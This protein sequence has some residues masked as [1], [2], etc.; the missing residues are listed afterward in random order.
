MSE[1]PDEV[2]MAV[3]ALE[4]Q[5]G[6][7]NHSFELRSAIYDLLATS[8]TL[9]EEQAA[10]I[11]GL[12]DVLEEKRENINSLRARLSE[13]VKVIEMF[14]HSVCHETGFANAVRHDSGH[15]YPWPALDQT[16]AA[17]KAFI[18][19]LGGEKEL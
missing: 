2:I 13:A 8:N 3:V 14:M 10:R 15:A 17:A 12:E 5:Y 6:D 16:E 18:T 1:L 9:I 11:A 7:G 4:K 19:T